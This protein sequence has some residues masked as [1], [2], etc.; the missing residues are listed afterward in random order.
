MTVT[1]TESLAV[2]GRQSQLPRGTLTLALALAVTVTV[3]L[4]VTGRQSQL[5]GAIGRVTG[6]IPGVSILSSFK[7]HWNSPVRTR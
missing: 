1:L 6:G 7:S 2:T 4:A 5:P 3:S